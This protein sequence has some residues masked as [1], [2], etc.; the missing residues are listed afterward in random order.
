MPRIFTD[1][2][3]ILTLQDNMSNSK[4][5]LKYRTPTTDEFAQYTNGMT[6]RRRNKLVNC[7]GDNRQKWGLKI[8]TG[9]REGDFIMPVNQNGL[10]V[11]KAISSDSASPNFEPSWRK[12]VA[13]HA[14]DLV[15]ALAIHV[16]ESTATAVD[17]EEGDEVV[18]PD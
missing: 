14:A 6:E 13:K 1:E 18:D 11:N 5:Q 3:N 15:E 17:P 12:L 4:I 10:T 9:F 2:D 7:T 8:M 16:F